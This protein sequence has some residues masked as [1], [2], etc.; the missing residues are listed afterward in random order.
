MRIAVVEQDAFS[1]IVVGWEWAPFFSLILLP[2]FNMSKIHRAFID[3]EC[4]AGLD[5]V[6]P[7]IKGRNSGI[8][9]GG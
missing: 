4:I 6:Q 7:Q 3:E 8:L 5:C 2:F 1:L 9:E